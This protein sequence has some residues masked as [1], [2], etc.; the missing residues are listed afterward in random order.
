MG[1]RDPRVLLV[2]A[3]ACWGIGTAV[4][5][6]AVA[7]IPA[8]TLLVVQ[9]TVSVVALGV[10]GWARGLPIRTRPGEA[11]IVRLGL[12]NPGLAYALGLIGLTQITA[13]LSVLIWAGEPILILLLAAL[14]L[15]EALP[16]WLVALS[17]LAIAGLVVVLA[18]PALS[19]AAIGVVLSTTGVLCCAMY[20]IA[21]RRWIRESDSTLAVVLGQQ[22]YALAFAAGL[23][24]IIAVGGGTVAPT[25]LTALTLASAV[26]SGLLYYAVAY[27]LYLSALRNMP[28]AVAATSF[29]LIPVFGL[30]GAALFGE[31]LGG[32]QWLGALVVIAAVAAI[33][34][35]QRRTKVGLSPA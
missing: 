33:G 27:W 12:L 35:F 32:P 2:G 22:A 8:V 13:S 23:V 1:A 18:A 17:G 31:R 20:T 28:A 26:A 4:S 7:D 5:K 25:S 9:L 34:W 11:A 24:V 29:Y 10:T 6:Q 21:A 14:L 19:G 30:T 16:A 3:A 15:H